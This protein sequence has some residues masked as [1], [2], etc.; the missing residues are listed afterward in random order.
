[1]SRRSFTSFQ[2]LALVRDVSTRAA[3]SDLE[4]FLF[5]S[6]TPASTFSAIDIVGNGLGRWKTMPI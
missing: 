4:I 6:R 5:T 2:R 3:A 1:L